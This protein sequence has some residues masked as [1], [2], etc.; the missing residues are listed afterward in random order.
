MSPFVKNLPIYIKDT[1][2]ALRIF[3]SFNSDESDA[4]PR[5]LS[6]MDI[7]SFVHSRP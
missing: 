6:T 5:F 2:H 4:R 3:Y 1:N 7:K